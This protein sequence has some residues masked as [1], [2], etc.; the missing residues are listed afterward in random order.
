MQVNSLTKNC[1]MS[2]SFTNPTVCQINQVDSRL[3]QCSSARAHG[4][5]HVQNFVL[6]KTFIL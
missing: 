2:A 1:M 5:K 4:L 6:L 3:R